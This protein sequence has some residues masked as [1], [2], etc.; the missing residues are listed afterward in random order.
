MQGHLA[1]LLMFVCVLLLLLF[2]ENIWM[3]N[4]ILQPL[5][6]WFIEIIDCVK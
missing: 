6:L 3:L 1:I 5:Q 4:G 2:V